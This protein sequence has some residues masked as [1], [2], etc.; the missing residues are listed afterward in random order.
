M[1]LSTFEFSWIRLERRH[2]KT[3]EMKS[4]RVV[5]GLPD[6][7]PLPLHSTEFLSDLFSS[8]LATPKPKFRVAEQSLRPLT[9]TP[10]V[11]RSYQDNA[12]AIENVFR[13]LSHGCC[14]NSSLHRHVVDN[15]VEH[16]ERWS[17]LS[18]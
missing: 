10:R 13:V 9:K 14:Q 7:F 8:I 6:S 11:A 17:G 1:V 12:F 4:P 2:V 16:L 3:A 15:A 18:G 5:D